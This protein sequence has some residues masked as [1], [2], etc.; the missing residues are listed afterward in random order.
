MRLGLRGVAPEELVPVDDLAH[1]R[2][3]R[4]GL[5]R[6]H[7]PAD[8]HRLAGEAGERDGAQHRVRLQQDVVVHEED[9]LAL[10]VASASYMTR[11]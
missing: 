9:L 2:E 10:G 8:Q 11:A 4:A 1:R 5:Q 6:Q 3:L 7:L